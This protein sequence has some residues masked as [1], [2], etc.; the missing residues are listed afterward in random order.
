MGT[1]VVLPGVLLVLACAGMAAGGVRRRAAWGVWAGAAAYCAAWCASWPVMAEATQVVDLGRYLAPAGAVGLVVGLGVLWR[2]LG[3]VARE[4]PGHWA[5]VAGVAGFAATAVV[6]SGEWSMV[7]FV[8][9]PGDLG[10]A[11]SE[12]HLV[13]GREGE[14]AARVRAAQAAV[15]AGAKVLVYMAEPAFLDFRRNVIYV[16]DW[17]GE[18]S[19]PPGMPVYSGGRAVAAYLRGLG[20]RYVVYGYGREAGFPRAAYGNYVEPVN[21]AV[22]RRQAAGS[23]AFQADLRE[24]E[25][26]AGVIYRNGEEEVLDLGEK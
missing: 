4:R 18:S 1:G 19:L 20:I 24:L 14:I 7:Y 9:V 26:E 23:F 16:A 22:V 5:R 6:T 15:P 21:G 17:P 2:V 8:A 25:G 10:R 3:E 12:A 13:R 11:T